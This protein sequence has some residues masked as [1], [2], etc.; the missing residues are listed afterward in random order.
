PSLFEFLE[1]LPRSPTGKVDRRALQTLAEQPVRRS[2]FVAPRTPLERSL[3]EAVA[4]ILGIASISIDDNFFELG[5]N[6]LTMTEIMT[7]LSSTYNVHLPVARVFELPT[8]EGVVGVIEAY[9]R[10]GSGGVV[11][12]DATQI[13]AESLLDPT[14]MPDW[15]ST[16]EKGY[17]DSDGSKTE[18]NIS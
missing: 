9:R 13:E 15:L 7:H 8:I 17:I 12:W 3:A 4:A 5:G 2:A 14:I 1:T 11:G 6:S 10:E 18:R 16:E